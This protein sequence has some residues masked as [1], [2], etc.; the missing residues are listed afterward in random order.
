[1]GA[2]SRARPP[3]PPA[4]PPTIGRRCPSPSAAPYPYSYT[5]SSMLIP[6]YSGYMSY[7]TATRYT[8]TTSM[9]V[10]VYAGGEWHVAQKNKEY[11]VSRAPLHCRRRHTTPEHHWLQPTSPVHSCITSRRRPTYGK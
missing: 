8:A 3:R 10:E 11:S 1:M 6:I 9:V 2:E 4:S 5:T 7:H